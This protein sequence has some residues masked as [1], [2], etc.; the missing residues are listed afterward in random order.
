MRKSPHNPQLSLQTFW[1]IV[2]QVSFSLRSHPVQPAAFF[3][4]RNNFVMIAGGFFRRRKRMLGLE[5]VLIAE[6]L[7][8]R[9]RRGLE[10]DFISLAVE[11][12]ITSPGQVD[13]S[14]WQATGLGNA[15]SLL[16]FLLAF[17]VEV[18][19]G[20]QLRF[21][22]CDMRFSLSPDAPPAGLSYRRTV[23]LRFQSLCNTKG[24]RSNPFLY[25]ASMSF[26]TEWMIA[27]QDELDLG[28]RNVT[29]G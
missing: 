5:T 27:Q 9:L 6:V 25:R 17:A 24:Q 15:V 16:E 26:T 7:N 14:L 11:S 12:L 29:Q 23:F 3:H 20:F 4:T 1:L 13:S 22:T 28:R 19:Y 21:V 10:A 8:R 2:L 18:G